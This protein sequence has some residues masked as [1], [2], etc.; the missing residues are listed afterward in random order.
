MATQRDG[1][2][3]GLEGT[4]MALSSNLAK[5]RT[6]T[7]GPATEGIQALIPGEPV[8]AEVF[9]RSLKR[10]VFND[11]YQ[12]F[13]KVR[14]F[15]VEK[16]GDNKYAFFSYD[17][18]EPGSVQIQPVVVSF[19]KPFSSLVNS[20][21]GVGAINT[22]IELANYMPDSINVW[23]L[24]NTGYNLDNNY[25]NSGCLSFTIN[26]GTSSSDDPFAEGT[27]SDTNI[28]TT[29]LGTRVPTLTIKGNGIKSTFISN[30]SVELSK[31]INLELK[32]LTVT[33]NFSL[34]ATAGSVHFDN[35]LLKGGITTASE[36]YLNRCTG[37][38]MIENG[39][40]ANVDILQL[41][42]E[43]ATKLCSRGSKKGFGFYRFSAD[44]NKFQ[45]VSFLGDSTVDDQSS[46]LGYGLLALPS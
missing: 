40:S 17:F 23:G 1:F 28:N 18:P 31:G 35:V 27:I 39:S 2:V 13:Q 22:F 43:V 32:D 20:G 3:T 7:T 5:V 41:N 42:K 44:Y 38:V 12:F 19:I 33:T 21:S 36:A 29:L 4:A 15:N 45:E 34:S 9:N 6:F 25:G 46:H 11:Y 26:V 37:N 16:N 14:N 8:I 10:L 30:L 24:S